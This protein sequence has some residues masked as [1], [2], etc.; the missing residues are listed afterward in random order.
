MRDLH[1]L[2]VQESGGAHLGEAFVALGKR[3]GERRSAG[4]RRDE[5]AQDGERERQH[6]DTSEHGESAWTCGDVELSPLPAGPWPA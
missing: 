1:D 5:L 6:R 3:W 2:D 4:R